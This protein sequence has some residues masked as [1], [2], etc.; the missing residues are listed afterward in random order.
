MSIAHDLP[1]ERD[2]EPTRGERNTGSP[3]KPG[4][5]RTLSG[6]GPPRGGAPRGPREPQRAPPEQPRPRPDQRNQRARP[7][8]HQHPPDQQPRQAPGR[9]S[10][11]IRNPG[12]GRRA[13]WQAAERTL[14][15]LWYRVLVA[16]VELLGLTS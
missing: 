5:R 1:Q 15:A 6:V 9:R 16:E 8:R 3:E 14:Y 2:R 11:G 12:G 10:N 4:D 13:S 7:P